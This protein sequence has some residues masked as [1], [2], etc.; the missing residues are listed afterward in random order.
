ML[1]GILLA[2]FLGAEDYGTLVFVMAASMAIKQLL[3]FGTSSAFFTFLSQQARSVKFVAQ[4]WVFFFVK[5]IITI[6]IILFILPGSWL[7]KIWLGNSS[8][9]AVIA[10]MAVVF[11][12]DFWTIASQLLESQRKTIRVQTLFVITQL[13]HFGF[14][15][16]LHYL[17]I[18][19][20]IN[21]LIVI[22]LLWLIAGAIAVTSYE[23]ARNSSSSAD[24]EV[25]ATDYIKYCLPLAPIIL[26]N[27]TAE[28]LDKWMLQNWGGAKQQAYFAI[29]AQ[30]ASVSL[31]ITASFIKIFWK[32]I[33]EAL[34]R[35]NFQSALTMY[36]G[37]RKAIFFSGVFIAAA[38]IPWAYEIL[39]L[40][41][42]KSYVVAAAPLI[43]LMMYSIHQSIGQVDSAFL[44]ASGNTSVGFIFNMLFAPIG[45][46]ITYI[47]LSN[48]NV[49]MIGLGLGASGLAIKMWVTQLIS[50]N[51][52]GVLI[53]K[54][55][56]IKFSYLDQIKVF[57]VF[58][59]LAVF[60]KVMLLALF[61]SNNYVF[62]FGIGLYA[63]CCLCVAL[64]SP[65]IIAL[66]VNWVQLIKRHLVHSP[67]I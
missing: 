52:I 41:Y 22:G 60:I 32:E 48:S 67:I 39:D 15:F 44:M 28:F 62:V 34:H 36:L 9:I 7:A 54:K 30:I 12:S 45:I 21:Y 14:I 20:V 16:E 13:I 24:K 59:L 43:L 2:R 4:F 18:L 6:A 3:D 31:L 5:Y 51:M 57:L 8:A 40:L 53:Q 55:L 33:A 66:P 47:L 19:T 10:L 61:P 42:G 35:G 49:L 29:S 58:I 50:V 37:A 1:V 38:C 17:G 56:D 64:V 23:P 25:F 46:L 65:R 11:Q 63:L 27:F 26:L